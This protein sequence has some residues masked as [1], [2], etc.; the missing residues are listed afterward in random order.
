M[1]FV[2]KGFCQLLEVENSCRSL[3]Y[4]LLSFRESSKIGIRRNSFLLAFRSA[5]HET[6]RFTS[7]QMLSVRERFYLV[8]FCIV[9]H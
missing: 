5:V 2:F 1:S 6:T 4:L 7:S 8:I 9:I 3:L